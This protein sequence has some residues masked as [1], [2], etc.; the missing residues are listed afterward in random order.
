VIG[1]DALSPVE[2]AAGDKLL[3]AK[4]TAEFALGHTLQTLNSSDIPFDFLPDGLECSSQG[5]PAC[6]QVISEIF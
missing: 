5:R 2:R 3:P 6:R 4:E 1:P